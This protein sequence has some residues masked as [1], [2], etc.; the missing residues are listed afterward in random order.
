MQ[1]VLGVQLALHISSAIYSDL[2][3]HIKTLW[4]MW[5]LLNL[6]NSWEII[7]PQ[8]IFSKLPPLFA[9]VLQLLQPLYILLLLKPQGHILKLHQIPDSNLFLQ[10]LPENSILVHPINEDIFISHC[11]TLQVCQYV[12]SNTRWI[13]HATWKDSV[14]TFWDEQHF[15]ISLAPSINLS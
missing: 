11:K 15:W 3:Q 1:I 5:M 12:S 4:A 10:Y 6:S 9:T 14:N 8:H 7:S 2:N 13:C